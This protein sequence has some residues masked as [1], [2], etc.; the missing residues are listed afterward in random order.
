MART[1]GAASGPGPTVLA[2]QEAL[3][4]ATRLISEIEAAQDL[5]RSIGNQLQSISDVE[6][7][8]GSIAHQFRISW[9][10]DYVN[11]SGTYLQQL[12]NLHQNAQNAKNVIQNILNAGST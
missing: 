6:G 8:Q 1:Q 7:W 9:A 4:A 12:N 2:T 5:N 11:R 10:G 3:D